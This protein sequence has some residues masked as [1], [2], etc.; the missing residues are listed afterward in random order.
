MMGNSDWVLRAAQ[1]LARH[2]RENACIDPGQIA[3]Q[4]DRMA[5]AALRVSQGADRI[6][7]VLRDLRCHLGDGLPSR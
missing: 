3:L 1:E 5:E 6:R 2:C 4:L 7:V